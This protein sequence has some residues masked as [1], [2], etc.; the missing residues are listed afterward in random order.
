MVVILFPH[1]ETVSKLVQSVMFE[2]VCSH[3]VMSFRPSRFSPNGGKLRYYL[4]DGIPYRFF[5]A[6]LLRMRA[7]TVSGRRRASGLFTSLRIMFSC[8]DMKA[9]T[10]LSDLY[11]LGACNMGVSDS[12]CWHLTAPAALGAFPEFPYGLGG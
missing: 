3:R 8:S 10:I 9:P 4:L 7:S 1:V 12:S 5:S 2:E 6:W 11:A